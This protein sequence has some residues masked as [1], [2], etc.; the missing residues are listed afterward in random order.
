M[1]PAD[2]R[3]ILSTAPPDE[4]DALAR[5]LLERRLIAC[6]NVLPGRSHYWWN[7]TIEHGEESMLVMKAPKAL[8]SRVVD[9]IREQ[10]RYEN[11]E[12]L[13]LPVEDGS[14]AYARWVGAE[15]TGTP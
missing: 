6:A 9:A 7:G 2:V 5:A 13:V 4:A 11:P 3:I 10:H 1:D 15:A 14:E 8:A 12:I